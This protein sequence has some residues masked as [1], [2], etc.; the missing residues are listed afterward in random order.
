MITDIPK[1]YPDLDEVIANIKSLLETK[2]GLTFEN[3]LVF[4]KKLTSRLE[5][6]KKSGKTYT[7]ESHPFYKKV[8][9]IHVDIPDAFGPEEK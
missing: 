1:I 5:E 3:G 8:K 2:N 4:D 6:M 7:F 9:A